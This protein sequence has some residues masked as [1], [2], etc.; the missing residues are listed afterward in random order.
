MDLQFNISTFE[1][2]ILTFLI[3]HVSHLADIIDY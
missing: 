3:P 1:F 2:P